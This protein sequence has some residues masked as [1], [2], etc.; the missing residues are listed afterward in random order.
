MSR[1]GT[2]LYSIHNTAH[3]ASQG[4]L[5]YKTQDSILLFYYTVG[6][7]LKGPSQTY[8]G[9]IKALQA[10]FFYKKRD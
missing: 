2:A 1:Q 5:K 10:I 8:C 3:Y 7:H 9:Q 6:I 4:Q